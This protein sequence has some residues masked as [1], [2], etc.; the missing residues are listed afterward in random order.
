MVLHDGSLAAPLRLIWAGLDLHRP[1]FT[2]PPYSVESAASPSAPQASC[3]TT[4]KG[5]GGSSVLCA[6]AWGM[7]GNVVLTVPLFS[8]GRP[9]SRPCAAYHKVNPAEKFHVSF[10]AGQVDFKPKATAGVRKNPIFILCCRPQSLIGI[11]QL[12]EG[13]CHD[14]CV[15]II[16]IASA[17]G[18]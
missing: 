16:V 13:G 11:C 5:D 12:E 6:H 9:C 7:S 1:P 15:T 17:Q 10:G 18:R 2:P 8:T 3:F 4:S 14:P